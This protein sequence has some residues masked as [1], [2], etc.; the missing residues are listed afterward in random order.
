MKLRWLSVIVMT[1]A[2]CGCDQI[3]GLLHKPGG[4]ERAVLGAY[5]FNEYSPKVEALQKLLKALGY[6]IGRPDG[7]FGA[8]TRE[9]VVQFQSDEGLKVT[10]FVDKATWE[11]LQSYAASPLIHAGQIN[12]KNV[13]LALRKAGY[14]PGKIDGRPGKQTRDAVKSFQRSRG[15]TPDGHVGLKTIKEL[16]RYLPPTPTVTASSPG[17][18]RVKARSSVKIAK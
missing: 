18:D 8:G 15:L 13:Q 3:Y 1:T 6:R 10:R 14:D 16:L 17:V 12:M 2:L 5:S 4:E 7:R 11:R 9:A